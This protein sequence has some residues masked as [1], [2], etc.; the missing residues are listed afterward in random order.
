MP[1]HP[2]L[3]AAF[4]KFVALPDY[5]ERRAPLLAFCE[6]HRVKGIILL[7]PEGINSTIAGALAD[8]HAVL[9]HLRQDP[10]LTDLQHKESFADKPPFHR[11][12][13]RLKREIVTMGVPDMD[14][15]HMAGT[16]VKPEDWNAPWIQPVNATSWLN[17][18]AG[19]S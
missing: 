9:A 4:Y 19:V 16:Y 14:P 13:V 11:M 2:Y 18:S 12:K 10:L 15:T 1:D 17:R 6:Q 7:A 5:A 3:T 8:V